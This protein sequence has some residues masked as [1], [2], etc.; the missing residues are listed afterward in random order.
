MTIAMWWRVT[1]G[2]WGL[3]ITSVVLSSCMTEATGRAVPVETKV[4]PSRAALDAGGG[5]R[6]STNY[7]LRISIGVP[8]ATQNVQSDHY[9]L[10]VG[11]GV[12]TA[13]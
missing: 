1:L 2:V 3:G 8:V 13:P 9:R 5:A 10:H 6:Q 7:R 4:Q 12:Y 11:A